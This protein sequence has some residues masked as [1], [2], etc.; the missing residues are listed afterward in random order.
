ML[1]PEERQEIRLQV[2]QELAEIERE[3]ARHAGSYNYLCEAA[4][5]TFFSHTPVGAVLRSIPHAPQLGM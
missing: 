5:V 1:S 2:H 4:G 3:V